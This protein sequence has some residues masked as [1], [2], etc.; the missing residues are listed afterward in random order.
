MLMRKIVLILAL[1]LTCS[2]V[3]AEWS[4]VEESSSLIAYVDYA[5]IRKYDNKVKMWSLFDYKN[6]QDAVG[7]NKR[8]LSTKSRNEY[9]CNEEK[10]RALSLSVYMGNMGHG[11]VIYS[12]SSVGPWEELPPNT[13]ARYLWQIGCGKQEVNP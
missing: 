4:Q 1:G 5:T 11:E 7:S 12:D 10:S 8:F 6:S 13:I 9:D 3:I 2:S